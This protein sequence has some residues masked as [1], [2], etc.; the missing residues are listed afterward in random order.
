MP[1]ITIQVRKLS[2][3]QNQTLILKIYNI[4]FDDSMKSYIYELSTCLKPI[5]WSKVHQHHSITLHNQY[6]TNVL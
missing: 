4:S 3:N 6:V 5:R 1:E 2:A